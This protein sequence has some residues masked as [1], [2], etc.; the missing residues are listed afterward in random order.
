MTAPPLIGFFL[1]HIMSK[2]SNS[3]AE[4]PENTGGHQNGALALG[5]NTEARNFCTPC[6]SLTVKHQGGKCWK[7]SDYQ[8]AAEYYRRATD[9]DNT[10][11]VYFSNL[12]AAYLKL[13]R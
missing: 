2:T 8:G 6:A 3:A 5:L 1:L 13:G 9:E 4:H 11:S 7:A 10:V 12:A